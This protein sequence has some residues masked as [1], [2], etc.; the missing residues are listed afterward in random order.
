MHGPDAPLTNRSAVRGFPKNVREQADCEYDA[1][2]SVRCPICMSER[3]L[4]H[5]GRPVAACASCKSLERGRRLW[6]VLQCLD[7]L[8]PGMRILHLAPERFLMEKFAALSGPLYHPCDKDPSRYRLKGVHV[9]QLDACSDLAKM[10]AACFD[11]I[12][13]NHVLE[14]IPCCVESTLR[15]MARIMAP[16]AHM[17]FSVPFRS[18]YTDEDLS[19]DLPMEERIRRFG[20]ADHLRIFG[21]RDFL[22]LATKALG[23]SDLVF[24]LEDHVEETVL[25]AAGIPVSP[26]GEL[27]GNTIFHYHA[28]A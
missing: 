20:Q 1:P 15:E 5:N 4:P 8:R 22:P 13:H 19:H 7:L 14:H 6:L 11:L 3:F 9:F 28:V 16:N 12:I 23:K 26:R 2:M 18:G 17:L 25:I 21:T 24:P 27:N 10:P